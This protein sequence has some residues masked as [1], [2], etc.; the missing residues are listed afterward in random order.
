MLLTPVLIA[1][2]LA[3]TKAKTQLQK[4][5]SANPF[6]KASRIYSPLIMAPNID[7]AVAIIILTIKA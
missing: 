1:L 6:K 4:I 5:P 2:M 7:I 3:D